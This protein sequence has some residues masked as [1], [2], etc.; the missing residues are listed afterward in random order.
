[1]GWKEPQGRQ[2]GAAFSVGSPSFAP[3]AKEGGTKPRKL[4]DW[5]N[6]YSQPDSLALGVASAFGVRREEGLG[7][8]QPLVAYGVV[9]PNWV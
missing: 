6:Y 3:T 5:R 8:G 2:L 4:G 9:K 7:L 1:V